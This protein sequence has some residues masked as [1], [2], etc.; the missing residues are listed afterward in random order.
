M[1][2]FGTREQAFAYM[3]KH[4]TR[5]SDGGMTWRVRDHEGDMLVIGYVTHIPGM[6]GSPHIPGWRADV[7]Y[8]GGDIELVLTTADFGDV[9]RMISGQGDGVRLNAD[10]TIQSAPC[11][12]CEVR[13]PAGEEL[14]WCLAPQGEWFCSD[15]YTE[16]TKE[17]KGGE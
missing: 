6:E 9:E 11:Q 4:A 13:V 7:L 12:A 10:G 15:C 14:G 16:N 8:G 1:R 2:N 5:A 3:D 17:P